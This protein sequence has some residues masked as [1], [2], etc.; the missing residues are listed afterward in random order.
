[1]EEIIKVEH[2]R[3]WFPV[4]L[5]FFETIFSRRQLFVRAVDGIDFDIK[6]GEIFALVG[7]S[8]S[9]KT[10]TGRLLLRLIEPT[11]GKIFFEGKD[12]TKIPEKEFKPYRRRMQMIFQDPYE[13]LN[14][15][16]TIFDIIAE[17][18]RVQGT[19]SE[20]QIKDKVYKVLTD[21]QL[22]PPEEFVY[23]YPHELSGGQRQR[24]A[25]AR[26]LTLDPEF[27]VADEPV[28]MLD[29]SIR[30]EILN[31]M[32]DLMKKYNV[33]FLYITHDLALARHICDTIA[34]MYLGKLMER[35]TAEQII[36]EPL[37]PY[38]K[39]L[40]V[41]VPSP[42]PDAKRV[43]VVIKGEIPSPINPPSGCRF[44]T[45]CPEFIGNICRQK[46]PPLINVGG[47]HFVACHLYGKT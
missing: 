6:K 34:V 5:G 41:A 19:L 31:L 3:K 33:T 27:V 37:H 30:A 35:G 7:E 28:S 4:R 21:V 15:K 36:Y 22:V 24:V 1:M 18:P 11:S 10:T 45:R 8:G 23:R 43:E 17:P 47:D 38:T 14:P 40:L 20:P 29:A 12:T 44:H 2:L 32:L 9:G 25:V 13:S 42:N 26:A 46:E 16:M 39:A